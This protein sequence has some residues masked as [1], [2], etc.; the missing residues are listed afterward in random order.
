MKFFIQKRHKKNEKFHVRA[1]D[2]T[3][4]SV[5]FGFLIYQKI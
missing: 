4:P 2:G 5:K 3:V 1:T